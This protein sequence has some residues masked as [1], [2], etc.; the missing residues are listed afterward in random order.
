MNS[1]TYSIDFAGGALVPLENPGLAVGQIVTYED[2]ANPEREFAVVSESVS[3][4]SCTQAQPLICLED[5]HF[6]EI[7][8]ANGKP[9]GHWT[10]TSRIMPADEL[11]DALAAAERNRVRLEA[12]RKAAAEIKAKEAATERAALI[13]KY[14]RKLDLV[15]P[16]QYASAAHGSK[17][18]KKELA[19][20]F[21]GVKFSVRSSTFSGGDSIDVSWTLGPT[22]KEVE[23]ITG[24]YQEGHFNGMEDIYEFSHDNQWP[25][26]FGGAKFVSESRHTP[27]ELFEQIGRALCALQRVEYNGQYT[28]GLMGENDTFDL[29]SHVHQ[30]LNVTPWPVGAEFKTVESTDDGESAWFAAMFEKYGS[31]WY[32]SANREKLSAE[33]LAQA[34]KWEARRQEKRHWCRIVFATPEPAPVEKPATTPPTV[35]ILHA[36][37][38]GPA[39]NFNAEKNGVEIRFPSKP[40]AEVLDRLK[41]AGWRWSRFSSCWYQRASVASA[42][43]AADVAGLSAEFRARLLAEI[44]GGAVTPT[45]TAAE[46]ISEATAA[47]NNAATAAPDCGELARRA[48]AAAWNN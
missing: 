19:A 41:S 20:A 30:L 36:A 14:G 21:P 9:C 12:E 48:L 38:N 45:P 27:P 1:K 2:R 46:T 40:A 18:L 16:G 37:D 24:K 31:G 8:F 42:N 6:A 17:N 29:G 26:L 23:A 11:K 34:E 22:Q 5:G 28:R 10:V 13:E 39:V 25:G 43:F 33:D 4:R 35:A 47:W 7:S 32:S 3:V 44:G 15:K